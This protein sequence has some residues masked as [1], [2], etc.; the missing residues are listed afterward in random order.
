MP[1]AERPVRFR[2]LLVER[3][4]AATIVAELT[5]EA[6]R[7]G[8]AGSWTPDREAMLAA[9]RVA[10]GLSRVYPTIGRRIGDHAARGGDLCPGV[11]RGPG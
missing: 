7:P 10:L 5:G 6:D 1:E 4:T 9:L 11:K 2:R 8:A 3:L